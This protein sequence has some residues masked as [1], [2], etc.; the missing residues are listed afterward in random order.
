MRAWMVIA[1]LLAAP[2][3]AVAGEL[4]GQAALA[5]LVARQPDPLAIHVTDGRDTVS[6]ARAPLTADTPMRIAS[7]TKTFVAATALRLWERKRLDLD[8]PIARLL[9]PET[10]ALLRQ[11]GYRT[12][13]ITVRQLLSHS[14]GLFDLGSDPR[15]H[16]YLRPGRPFHLSREDQVRLMTEYADPQSAPGTRYQYSD[17]DYIL[18]GEII[19]RITRLPLATAVRRE[20]RFDRLGLR[21]TWWEDVEPQPRGTPRRARQFI[22]DND[23]TD[24]DASFDL[25]GGGGLVAS[26]RDL[27]TFFR[28]LF[29]GRVFRDRRTL[30]MM[31]WKGPHEGADTYRLGIFVRHTPCGDI[32]WHSGFWGTYAGYAPATGIALA[33]FSDHQAG[34]KPVTPELPGLFFPAGCAAAAKRPL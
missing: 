14:G 5:E 13:R 34:L 18:I 21:S 26:P 12:D 2:A 7:N 25:Y 20:L 10:D 8:A 9:K 33:A 28:A 16:A 17:G 6:D 15:Y 23:V 3:T 19:E 1:A 32:W 30:D 24:V 29:G 22:G 31:L 4:P 27:A 11:D